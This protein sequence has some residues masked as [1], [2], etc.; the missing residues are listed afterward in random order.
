L[1]YLVPNRLTLAFYVLRYHEQWYSTIVT[2]CSLEWADSCAC[3]GLAMM[4]AK[5][6]IPT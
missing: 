2:S 1:D 6:F 3:V 4:S 5:K